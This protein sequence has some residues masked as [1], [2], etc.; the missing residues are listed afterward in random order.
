MDIPVDPS[1]PFFAY[2][3]FRPGALGFCLIKRYVERIASGHACGDLLELDGLPILFDGCREINGRLIFFREQE[4]RD[5]YEGICLTEPDKIYKWQ[6]RDCGEAKCNVLWAKKDGF[7]RSGVHIDPS[8]LENDLLL[9]PLL[10]TAREL[11]EQGDFL[12]GLFRSQAAYSLLWSG[13]ERYTVLFFGLSADPTQRV[14]RLQE[15]GVFVEALRSG[16]LEHLCDLRE[17]IF[18]AND[19]EEK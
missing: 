10:T 19:P 7:R 15:S 9:K 2:G 5:A 16:T 4:A 12:D 11:R 13:I 1:L 17:R 3:L 18:R 14:S 8:K 6:E